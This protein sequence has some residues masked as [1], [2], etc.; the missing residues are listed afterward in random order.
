MTAKT[1]RYRRDI[2]GLRA[3]AVMSVVLYHYAPGSFPGGFVGVDVFFVIS[4][5]LITRLIHDAVIANK[6]SFANFYLR[7]VRRLFPALLFTLLASTIAAVLILSPNHLTQYGGSLV[8]AIFSV[9]NFF[10][11]RQSGYFDTTADTKPLLH[12]WSLSVEEQFYLVWPA[13]LFLL[14]TKT[15]RLPLLLV[16]GALGS[17]SV[18]LAERWLQTDPSAAFFLAPARVIEL[19]SG[20]ALVPLDRYRPKSNTLLEAGALAGLL[21]I[22]YSVFRFSDKT[23]FPGVHGLVPTVGAALV[24]FCGTARYSGRVLTSRLAVGLGLISYSLYLVH[25]PIYVF[26]SYYFDLAMKIKILLIL[27]SVGMAVLMYFFIEIPFRYP[28]ERKSRSYSRVLMYV[29]GVVA[30]A[31]VGSAAYGGN[32]WPWRFSRDRAQVYEALGDVSQ[33]VASR[34]QMAVDLDALSFAPGK[35]NVLVVGDSHSVDLGNAFRYSKLAEQFHVSRIG[36]KMVCFYGSGKEL[37][38]LP[39]STLDECRTAFD[40]FSRDPRLQTADWVMLALRWT[41]QG[42]TYLERYLESSSAEMRAKLVVVGRTAEFVDVPKLAARHG[43]VN[44]L[45]SVLWANRDTKLDGL[46]ERLK[47][48]A[49]R[50]GVRYVDKESVVCSSERSACDALDENEKMLI[51]DYGHWTIEGAR[52]YGNKMRAQGVLDFMLK[53]QPASLGARVD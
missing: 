25:W 39:A 16:V 17:V 38:G 26:A 13:V 11:W 29:C 1:D 45:D 40:A 9:S 14:L 36:L 50:Y 47:R 35:I 18:Y 6:F 24:I 48:L 30:A 53:P 32:G 2:D 21:L 42:L 34:H 3:I 51:F 49:S 43:R 15:P 44:G 33:I 23:P 10:F 20:A 28:K 46:N 8:S 37:V 5:Y 19:A 7:R 12:T 41:D 22:A 4:G 52:F 27:G 31:S